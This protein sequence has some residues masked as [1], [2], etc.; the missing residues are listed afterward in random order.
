MMQSSCNVLQ[1]M[2]TLCSNLLGLTN[3]YKDSLLSEPAG[4][5]V[6][7]SY[8]RFLER[9]AHIPVASNVMRHFFHFSQVNASAFIFDPQLFFVSR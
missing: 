4:L 5:Q 2:G 8:H 6:Y 3:P 1:G 9:K 7:V